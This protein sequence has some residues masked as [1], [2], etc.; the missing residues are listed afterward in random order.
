[1]A[2]TQEK[3]RAN[4]A[5]RLIRSES[6]W[7]QKAI[8]ALSKAEDAREKLADL[9]DDRYALRVELDGTEHSVTTVSAALR[10]VVED[11]LQERRVELRQ[12]MKLR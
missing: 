5:R 3:R 12:R 10:E 1:V 4:R 9:T 6:R 8:F 11:R 7:L 2:T